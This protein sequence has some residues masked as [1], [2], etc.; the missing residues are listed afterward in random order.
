VLSFWPPM[1]ATVTLNLNLGLTLSKA[2]AAQL[3]GIQ[4]ILNK[5]V[6]SMGG[7]HT[8]VVININV[9]PGEAS[10][11]CLC[12]SI[13]SGLQGVM[14]FCGPAQELEL[15]FFMKGFQGKEQPF[16][17]V[18]MVAVVFVPTTAP[19]PSGTPA[20]PAT[21]TITLAPPKSPSV[22]L[23]S[24]YHPHR[25]PSLVSTITRIVKGLA[26]SPKAAAVTG[27]SY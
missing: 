8:V 18:S 1:Q 13:G 19:P 11:D 26:T 22:S 10:V 21:T 6:L 12:S 20:L 16:L 5:L 9:I 14:G 17:I 15:Q 27:G 25:E 24:Q 4:A 23:P 7:T 3:P 2:T